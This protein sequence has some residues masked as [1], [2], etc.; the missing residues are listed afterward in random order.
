[1]RVR[2]LTAL[3]SGHL[4][5]HPPDAP[6]RRSDAVDSKA[7]SSA[8]LLRRKNAS[9]LQAPPIGLSS[10]VIF[11]RRTECTLWC[12]RHPAGCGGAEIPVPL[13]PALSERLMPSLKHL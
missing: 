8:E 6:Q 13:S 12:V 11:S 10:A 3:M 4:F 2:Q 5:P 9:F 1:M 7:G